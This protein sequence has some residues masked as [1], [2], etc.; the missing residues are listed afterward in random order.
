MRNRGFDAV[1]YRAQIDRQGLVPFCRI[2]L[3]QRC[4]DQRPASIV[5]PDI[6]PAKFVHCTR[7]QGCHVFSAGDIGLVR[8]RSAAGIAFVD[9][10][11][12]MVDLIIA[13]CCTNHVCA[14]F[15]EKGCNTFAN[16]SAS[17]RNNRHFA[18]QIE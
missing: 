18:S 12:R 14:S 17:A 5:D 10:L 13:A 3:C 16:A 2:K 15:S 11:S 1:E 4:G 7:S 9:Q 8:N 6:Q